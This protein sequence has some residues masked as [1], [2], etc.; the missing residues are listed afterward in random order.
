MALRGGRLVRSRE[1]YASSHQPC[2]SHSLSTLPMNLTSPES[3]YGL[4][5]NHSHKKAEVCSAES[6]A[7]L[8]LSRRGLKE[9]FTGIRWV[10]SGAF[11][12]AN[13]KYELRVSVQQLRNQ[14][15]RRGAARFS[16]ARPSIRITSRTLTKHAT[17]RLTFEFQLVL[18]FCPSLPQAH[19]ARHR[20]TSA[21]QPANT[22]SRATKILDIRVW[23]G[24]TCDDSPIERRLDVPSND[25]VGLCR[26]VRFPS[27]RQRRG[28]CQSGDECVGQSNAD[29]DRALSELRLHFAGP[30]WALDEF[31]TNPVGVAIVEFILGGV[32][33]Q[34][35]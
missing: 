27:R 31:K 33:L 13:K 19:H 18:L 21:A 2:V 1:Q 16:A 26:S 5:V 30:S 6:T 29:V 14:L 7:A 4:V 34:E 3:L 22:D 24:V 35:R 23:R 17:P 32:H 9:P 8:T 12:G 20:L 11:D 15:R 28:V 25:F 10:I